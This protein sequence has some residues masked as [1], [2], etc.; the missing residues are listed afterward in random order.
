MQMEYVALIQ[1]HKLSLLWMKP[2]DNVKHSREG[3]RTCAYWW[4]ARVPFSKLERLVL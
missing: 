4:T 1:W 2:C 3:Q